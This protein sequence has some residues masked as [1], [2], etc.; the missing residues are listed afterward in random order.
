MASSWSKSHTTLLRLMPFFHSRG[1]P[2]LRHGVVSSLDPAAHVHQLQILHST[3]T[4]RPKSH[5]SNPQAL[6]PIL[7]SPSARPSPCF[8][9]RWPYGALSRKIEALQPTPQFPLPRCQSC[10]HAQHRRHRTHFGLRVLEGE[11]ERDPHNTPQIIRFRSTTLPGARV[12]SRRL[13]GKC[14]GLGG[15]IVDV[16]VEG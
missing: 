12:N 14:W 4:L 2:G 10:D 3:L 15:F 9:L 11:W 5:S 8:R 1:C 6:F 13:L 16:D 7:R